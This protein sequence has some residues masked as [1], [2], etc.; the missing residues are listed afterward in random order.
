MVGSEISPQEKDRRE[1]QLFEQAGGHESD[2]R[3]WMV[4][5]YQFVRNRYQLFVDADQIVDKSMGTD[6]QR[7]A[8]ALSVMTNPAIM[9]YLDMKNV[10]EDFAVEPFAE[11][12]PGRYLAKMD[13]NAMM[14]SVMGNNV[15]GAAP[16]VPGA[17]S[18]PLQVTP[19]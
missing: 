16:A 19:S 8:L 13:A 9:P 14:R 4:N 10:V 5:P 7:A 12:D 17:P 3:I 15:P 18:A 2:Q 1:W 6:Q 11:G